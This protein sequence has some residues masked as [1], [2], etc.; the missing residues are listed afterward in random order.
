MHRSMARFERERGAG[1]RN[2]KPTRGKIVQIR[3]KPRRVLR[4]QYNPESVKQTGGVGGW[5]AIDRR[6]RAPLSEWTGK[7]AV[8]LQFTLFFDGWPNQSIEADCRL[9][10]DMGQPRAN[11]EPPPILSF[12][13]GPVGGKREWVIENIEWGED[14]RRK[15]LRRV[16]ATAT[17][18]L[19]EYV[20]SRLA[21]TPVEQKRSKQR[22]KQRS[23][24]KPK[25][26][27]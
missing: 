25:A 5:Q 2:K 12:D 18:T 17:V 16:R 8:R 21:L 24:T 26:T 9:L 23:T 7:P 14:V 6:K 4:F 10:E 13:Y 15:D 19:M 11:E 22:G 1:Q 27:D 3:P 20:S